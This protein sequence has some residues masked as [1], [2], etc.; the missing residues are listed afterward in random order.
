[1]ETTPSQG[2]EALAELPPHEVAGAL[3]NATA[4]ANVKG[5]LRKRGLTYEEFAPQ[6]GMTRGTLAQR[7]A[8]N[9]ALSLPELGAVANALGIEPS[10]LLND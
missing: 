1:M 4:V 10:K 8:G 2:L 9:T 7:M 6:I 3:I 5:E